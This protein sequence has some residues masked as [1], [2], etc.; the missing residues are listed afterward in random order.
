MGFVVAYVPNTSSNV[1]V[2][3]YD[4][5]SNV[6]GKLGQWHC[7]QVPAGRAPVKEVACG[8]SHL[9]ALTTEGNGMFYHIAGK[10]DIKGLLYSGILG[11]D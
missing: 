11:E 2:Q 6:F 8:R 10:F 3:P 7:L 9:V 1:W 5:R 4:C